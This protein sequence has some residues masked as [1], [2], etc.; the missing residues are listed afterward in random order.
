MKT[1]YIPD[2][3]RYFGR[4]RPLYRDFSFKFVNQAL[5]MHESLMKNDVLK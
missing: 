1:A 3:Q 2:P 4:Q 5:M